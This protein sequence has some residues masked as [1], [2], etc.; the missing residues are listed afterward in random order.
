MSTILLT[1]GKITAGYLDNL[2]SF[3]P[4]FY[5]SEGFPY[6]PYLQK[7]QRIFKNITLF[8]RNKCRAHTILHR[9]KCKAGGES[10]KIF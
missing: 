10:G 8:H 9:K 7:N 4:R 3:P 5:V 1:F 6:T 2:L